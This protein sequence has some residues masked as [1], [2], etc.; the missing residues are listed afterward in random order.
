M[1]ESIV[2]KNSDP[3]DAAWE[4][5]QQRLAS[6]PKSLRWEQWAKEA[7]KLNPS[8]AEAGETESLQTI[9]VSDSRP[10][11]VLEAER[12]TGEMPKAHPFVRWIKRRRKRVAV[13]A[14][15]LVLAAFLSTPIGN[16]ALASILN[17]FRMQEMTVVQEND[18]MYLLNS[19]FPEGQTK[20]S[21]N[22]LGAF[23]NTSGKIRGTFEANELSEMLGRSVVFPQDYNA[24]QDKPY[25]SP[26]NTL[27]LKLNVDEVNRAMSR[28]GAKQ[29][30][31]ESVDGK[32]ITLETGE[33]V[34]LNVRN[35]ERNYSLIQQPIPVVS[36][37]P[38]IPV[39]EALQAVLQFPL[40]PENLKQ[41]LQ[42]VDLLTTGNVPLPIITNRPTEKV[43]VGNT[44][45]L[46]MTES[47]NKQN[48]YSAMWVKQGQL[49]ELYG[50]NYLTDRE[51]LLGKVKGLIGS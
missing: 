41:S 47:T 37:D 3:T 9:D 14:A 32:A 50:H 18:L 11:P 10:L 28:L 35:G 44:D 34:H 51:A 31:P 42:N 7:N 24:K 30:L 36:V 46:I 25:V 15:V 22:K 16:E 26:S 33:Q 1:T 27:T 6:E 49:F 23:T 13:S 48:Y 39:A 4:K 5:F 2:R 8:A 29:M 19:A 45:V 40:L 12:T 38:S 20:E 43:K 17:K 21:I